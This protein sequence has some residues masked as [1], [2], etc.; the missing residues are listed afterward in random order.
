MDTNL[1][2][3][4]IYVRLK[5]DTI[6]QIENLQAYYVLNQ[7]DRYIYILYTIYIYKKGE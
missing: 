4:H 6:V 7:Q 5:I 3:V 2:Y 1:D